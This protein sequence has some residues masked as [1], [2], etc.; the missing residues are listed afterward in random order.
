MGGK[1]GEGTPVVA[2]RVRVAVTVAQTGGE[3]IMI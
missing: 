2:R 3:S 1:G